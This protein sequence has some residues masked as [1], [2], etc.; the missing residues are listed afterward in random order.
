M[1]T[2]RSLLATLLAT[3]CVGSALASSAHAQ[4]A[5]AQNAAAISE[6]IRALNTALLATM[7]SGRATP[8]TQRFDALA[9]VVDRAFD[10]EAILRGAVG[11]RWIDLPPAEQDALRAEFRRFTIASWV[12]GF[13]SFA[14]QTL[15][16]APAPRDV[17]NGTLVVDTW[18][19]SPT[20]GG[21][22]LGYVM[23]ETGTGWRAV[24]ILAEGSIS[25]VAVL[26]SDFRQALTSGGAMAL[27]NRL[28]EKTAA[29][30]KS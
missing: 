24:D 7:K 22:E 10:L 2:R 20:G 5:H 6:P 14:G 8:F 23:R 13:D 12:A 15:T 30:G 18:L 25:R 4:N 3:A 1:P 28:R 11:G 27:L 16:I 29:L 17:G 19:A 21:V 26:R 9:P